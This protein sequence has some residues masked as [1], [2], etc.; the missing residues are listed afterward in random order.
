MSKLYIAEGAD[1]FPSIIVRTSRNRIPLHDNV[2]VRV[3]LRSIHMQYSVTT[4]KETDNTLFSSRLSLPYMSLLDNILKRFVTYHLVK[5]YPLVFG[6]LCQQLD[7]EALYFSNIFRSI[8]E[9]AQRSQNPAFRAKFKQLTKVL[10][11]QQQTTYTSSSTALAAYLDDADAEDAQPPKLSSDTA[12][13]LSMEKLFCNGVKRPMFKTTPV[14]PMTNTDTHDDEELSR[15]YPAE[16]SHTNDAE[17]AEFVEYDEGDQTPSIPGRDYDEAFDLFQQGFLDRDWAADDSLATP[18]TSAVPTTY[19]NMIFDSDADDPAYDGLQAIVDADQMVCLSSDPGHPLPHRS[20]KAPTNE[21][22]NHLKCHTSIFSESKAG[23]APSASR[24]FFGSR[25]VSDAEMDFNMDQDSDIVLDMDDYLDVLPH[26]APQAVPRP[27]HHFL[28][29]ELEISEHP[30][31][32]LLYIDSDVDAGPLCP[33]HHSGVLDI[34]SGSEPCASQK[35]VDHILSDDDMKSMDICA[36]NVSSSGPFAPLAHFTASHLE[37]G[38]DRFNEPPSLDFG[39]DNSD[40]EEQEHILI[41]FPPIHEAVKNHVIYPEVLG[42]DILPN[43]DNDDGTVSG[44]QYCGSFTTLNSSQSSSQTTQSSLASSTPYTLLSSSS[45]PSSSSALPVS[46]TSLYLSQ[47]EHEN[48]GN[49]NHNHNADES[50]CSRTPHGPDSAFKLLNYH[51]APTPS[52]F[53]DSD[54]V[55]SHKFLD[56]DMLVNTMDVEF[57]F[58]LEADT[59]AD[60]LPLHSQLHNPSGFNTIASQVNK[61]RA[62]DD[63]T[64]GKSDWELDF[65]EDIL[66]RED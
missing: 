38:S 17:P 40:Q 48:D 56:A 55:A 12:F 62:E 43:N 22:R 36:A 42:D 16:S 14:L 7:I 64:I 5:K 54:N 41:S 8:R 1:P 31:S 18:P 11:K 28:E 20:P 65:T 57:V 59:D 26:A 23:N 10:M 46:P 45:G 50:R 39:S 33:L 3:T 2:P 24:A 4:T 6:A 15:D 32:D 51:I 37:T 19:S 63:V 58:N 60:A 47:Y 29:Y 66:G 9:M 35:G 52:T 34:D 27:L 61:Y 30:S 44:M 13:C 49:C 53:K 25:F 21:H